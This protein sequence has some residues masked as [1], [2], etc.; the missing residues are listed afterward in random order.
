MKPILKY[1][2]IF[3]IPVF[4]YGQ[5]YLSGLGSNPVIKSYLEKNPEM[6]LYKSSVKTYPSIYPPLID[7][8]SYVG[9]YPDTMIWVDNDAYVNAEYPI[10][11]VDYGVATMDVLNSEGDIYSNAT[12]F[13]FEAD[14]LTSYPVRLDSIFDENHI[15]LWET[16]AADSIYLSFYYQPQGLGDV[17]LPNDSLVL[18]FGHYTDDTVFSHIEFMWLR[19]DSLY[20]SLGE[21]FGE[22][23][24]LFAGAT[25]SYFGCDYN[26]VVATKNYIYTDSIYVPCDSVSIV[27]TEWKNIWAVGGQAI[28]SFLVQNN[29]Y[30]KRVMIPITDTVWLR[31]DFQFRFF[32]Y[33]SMSVINSW[34]SNTDHWHIDKVYLGTGRS[35]NDLYSREIRFVQPAHSLLSPYTSIPLWHYDQ[36]MMVDTITVYTNNLDSIAH[37][38]TYTYTVQD[39][40][41]ILLPGFNYPGFTDIMEP[42]ATFDINSYK[43]FAN[44]PVNSYFDY[45][46]IDS[47]EFTVNHMINDD[48]E[49]TVG[50]T[51][52]SQQR[53]DNYFAYDDGTAERSYGASSDNTKMVVQFRTWTSDT[54][55]GVQI[56]FNKVQGDYNLRNFD[57]GVWS[58][59]NGKPGTLIDTMEN[60]RPIFL[61]SGEFST[62]LFSDII[63]MG[64]DVFYIG[65]IQKTNDN[66]NIGFDKNTNSR[67][68]TFYNT[69]GQWINS[70]FDGSLMIRPLFGKALAD[71]GKIT[72]SYPAELK[73][74]PN[75]AGNVQF[76][77]LV[78]PGDFSDPDYKK[79][80]TLRIF[81]LYG[82]KVYSS[83]FNEYLDISWLDTGFYIIDIFD[84]AYT[85]HY[86]TKMLVEKK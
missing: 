52:H 29:V 38:C 12:T 23:D 72:K 19:I 1:L 44:I 25:I 2:F 9:V 8:F 4:S 63:R 24:T 33:G 13:P 61:G 40:S 26:S 20:N 70:P 79:Y 50:D 65:V 83:Q 80:L 58:D 36:D 74:Y 41:G 81:D 21:P 48:D 39:E 46:E 15:G 49:L 17:P 73:I 54:L 5:V 56:Y 16:T 47:A 59:N 30:F 68:K 37:S 62:Y 22:G 66:L 31:S 60:K 85:R 42:Y 11:P 77:N 3:L 35:M 76:V 43:P 55:R 64:V 86:T 84:A 45:L 82:R 78:L 71:S 28:D 14:F 75:P 6:L 18:Q 34:K 69:D 67:S 10:F 32:N 53:F 57:I 7:D 27:E 51:I